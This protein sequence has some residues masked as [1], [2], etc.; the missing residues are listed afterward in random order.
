MSQDQY[1]VVTG[2]RPE[3]LAPVGEVDAQTWGDLAFVKYE[4]D[5]QTVL[6]FRG[7]SVLAN[8]APQAPTKGNAW[9]LAWQTRELKSVK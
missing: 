7:A 6:V 8:R 4:S 9:P 1:L 3:R 5:Q 2:T